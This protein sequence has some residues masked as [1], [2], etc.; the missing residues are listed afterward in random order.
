M[1]LEKLVKPKIK[2]EAIKL[3][4]SDGDLDK[5][6]IKSNIQLAKLIGKEIDSNKDE[7]NRKKLINYLLDYISYI[8]NGELA[9]DKRE[10]LIKYLIDIENKKI[11]Y[12]DI[13]D[14]SVCR[15]VGK[16][17]T[18]AVKDELEENYTEYKM[19]ILDKI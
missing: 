9:E 16:D 1:K 14:K 19:S 5:L 15:K 10:K 13:K 7:V 6:E 12:I 8:S 11:K 3:A 17:Y 4:V 18:V 2:C